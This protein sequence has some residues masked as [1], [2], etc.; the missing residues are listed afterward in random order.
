MHDL[1]GLH[2]RERVARPS[3]L[4]G[5]I[6]S[7]QRGRHARWIGGGALI[8][9][10]L[11]PDELHDW[12]WRVPFLSGPAGRHVGYLLRRTSRR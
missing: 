1:H 2:D 12:G 4:T 6:A 3:G 9:T 8:A 11:S 7:R 5:A 10:L